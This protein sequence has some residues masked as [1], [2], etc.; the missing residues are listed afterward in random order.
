MTGEILFIA[1]R[2]PFPPDRGDKIR[3][4]NVLKHLA[5]LAPVHV[6]TFA[7]DDGDAT[8]EADLAAL[9]ASYRVVRRAKPLAIAAVQ[10][11]ALEPG[12]IH[13]RERLGALGVPSGQ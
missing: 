1:H 13:A 10:A 2:L 7:D 6:A 5:G 12:Q 3:S 9:A 8:A 4:H 11:L